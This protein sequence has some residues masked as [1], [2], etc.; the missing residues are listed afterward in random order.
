MNF[1]VFVVFLLLAAPGAAA[2]GGD[3]SQADPD[4]ARQ[5]FAFVLTY[6]GKCHGKGASEGGGDMDVTEPATLVENGYLEPDSPETSE[7]WRRIAEGEMPPEGEPQPTAREGEIFR[8]WIAAGAPKPA[9]ARREFKSVLDTHRAIADDLQAAAE[10]DRGRLVYFTLVHLYN[11]PDVSDFDLRL[12]RAA[13]SKAINSLSWQPE[14]VVPQ[15]IDAEGTLLRVDLRDLGWDQKDWNAILAA[16]PY[17]LTYKDVLD[18]SLAETAR[19]IER[20][21]GEGRSGELLAVRADWFVVTA[22][23]PPLYHALLDIPD[24][25]QQLEQTLGVDP[26]RNFRENRLHRAGFAESGVSTANRLVE[27]H[28]SR[29]GRGY[30]WKSYDFREDRV[31]SNLFQK[32]LGPQFPGNPHADFAFQHDGGELIF[33]LPNGLQGYM[34]VGGDGRRIDAG[35]IEV[36]QDSKRTSGSPLVV[37][38]VS[39]MHCHA[40]GM[41]SF[42]DTV[43]EGVALFGDA[44]QKVQEIYPSREVM[45]RLVERDAAAFMSALEL[46]VAPFLKVAEDKNKGLR[47]FPEPIGA[48][49][50]AYHRNVGLVEAACELGFEDPADL[51]TAIKNSSELRKLGIAP[52]EVGRTIDR[53]FWESKQN[54]VSPM[55]DAAR[56]M[57]F[58]TPHI[59]L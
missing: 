11:H 21:A 19:R 25:A 48:A 44:R 35:P 52:L 1:R 2:L 54:L 24:H 15:S 10:S 43:R 33:S 4:V 37:N 31:K 8:R 40:H 32:P 34:L 23:R 36:V 12:H 16:Y 38:G 58:G 28:A 3:A 42:R 5:G 45:D 27:R 9:R 7:M 30:Y 17:G 51:K 57:D 20:L 26:V 53:T 22:M 55:Q 14:I 41:I 6:C 39:C 59:V 18:K 46:A 13:L 49:A 50:R 56:M 47:E 29:T